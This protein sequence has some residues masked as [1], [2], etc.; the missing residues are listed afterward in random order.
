M[1][2]YTTLADRINA[3]DTDDPQ[4]NLISRTDV[5]AIVADAVPVEIDQSMYSELERSRELTGEERETLAVV[6]TVYNLLA[7]TA[8]KFA[9]RQVRKQAE[10]L[11]VELISDEEMFEKNKGMPGGITSYHDL[12]HHSVELVQDVG[13]ILDTLIEKSVRD[14]TMGLV[15]SLSTELISLDGLDLLHGGSEL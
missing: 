6:S 13:G 14:A 4:D 9:A 10:S 3:L 15:L 7:D 12:A 1:S 5:L 11:G 8:A 2:D